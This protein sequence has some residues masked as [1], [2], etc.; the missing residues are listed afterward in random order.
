MLVETAS[1]KLAPRPIPPCWAMD[2]ILRL[3]ESQT[4]FLRFLHCASGLRRQGVFLA[5]TRLDVGD[6][7]KFAWSLTRSGGRPELKALS[8]YAVVASALMKMRVRE[9]LS[10]VFGAVPHGLLSALSRCGYDPLEEDSYSLLYA[11]CD[12]PKNEARRLLLRHVQSIDDKTLHV[13]WR[14]P[15]ALLSKEVLGQ[16]TRPEQIEQYS[17]ALRL[18]QGLHPS[19]TEKD[20]ATSLSQM[21]G[22]NGLARWMTRWVERADHLPTSLP[23]SGGDVLRPLISAA[24][25][26]DA[27]R[28]Y[29]NCLRR[30]I[31]DVA[32][33]RA[34][35]Y[36]HIDGAVAELRG[37]SG[38]QWL[39]EGIY[40][41]Q[42]RC[43]AGKVIYSIR[44]TLEA[45]GVLVPV[46]HVQG[47]EHNALAEILGL[48]ELSGRS[49][50]TW[51]P[52][53][54]EAA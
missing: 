36:E 12:D 8:P 2:A 7:C 42:N 26:K 5:L 40:G 17:S 20:L 21:S 32:L 14:L 11:I 1:R 35:Y 52:K 51:D 31:G 19:I 44:T 29:R 43:P 25:M 3:D 48:Y 4:G 38:G 16:I 45:A 30:R 50:L 39:L 6:V 22:M 33:G 46:A 10:F 23:Y 15:K 49:S 53:L 37:L 24:D 47:R 41:P 28:R 13:V 27:A 18:I 54:L 34:I 9:I